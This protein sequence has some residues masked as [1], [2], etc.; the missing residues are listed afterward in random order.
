MIGLSEINVEETD[1]LVIMSTVNLRSWLTVCVVGMLFV[2]GACADDGT[3]PEPDP[4]PTVPEPKPE[5][6]EPYLEVSPTALSFDI[7]G[8]ALDAEAFTVKS[9]CA[10]N[11]KIPEHTDWFE[12]SAT[13][14]NGDGSVSFRLSAD[15]V[16]HVADLIF[17]TEASDGQSA[18]SQTVTIRQGTKP[19]DTDPTEPTDPTDPENPDPEPET[20]PVD[21]LVPSIIAVIPNSLLWDAADRNVTKSITVQVENFDNQVLNVAIEGANK[22]R[23]ETISPVRDGFVVRVTNVGPNET[24]ADYT[25]SLIITVESGNSM[26]VPLIQSKRV[27]PDSGDGDDKD[28]DGSDDGGIESGGGCDDFSYLEP[29]STYM[30]HIGPTPAGWIGE[31]CAVYSGG[32]PNSDPYY[33]SL[34]GADARVIGLSMNGKTTAVGKIVSPV[35]HGGCGILSFDYG[36]TNEE[37]EHVDFKVEIFRNGVLWDTFLVKNTVERLKKNTFSTDV[38]VSGDFQIVFTNNCPSRESKD[39]DRYTIFHIEWTGEK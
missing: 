21:S 14:G 19:V 3:V 9:N 27:V 10:W 34:L 23:F 35:L 15:P 25:A 12:A 30:K 38:H 20:P 18:L 5:M 29:N 36:I 17:S 22:D 26:T 33:P 13:S 4:T 32:G 1:L 28:D 16:Y 39:V 7:E 31:N 24:D 37:D 8:N 6:K 11:L 2:S